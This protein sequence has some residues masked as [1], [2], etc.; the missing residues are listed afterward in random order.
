MPRVIYESSFQYS[1]TI[2]EKYQTKPKQVLADKGSASEENY[3]YMEK[4]DLNGYIPHPKLQQNLKGGSIASKKTNTLISMEIFTPSSSLPEAK[5]REEEEDRL[6]QSQQ[7]K[8]ISNRR[9][10]R[11]KRKKGKTSSCR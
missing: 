4:Q 5:P 2:E 10:I 8:V 1:K 3:D 7:R 6:L 9:S 11:R